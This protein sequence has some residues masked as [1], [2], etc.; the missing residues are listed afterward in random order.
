MDEATTSRVRARAF[1]LWTRAGRPVGRD[2]DIWLEAERHVLAGA[3][4][5]TTPAKD[6][7]ASDSIE[8][9]ETPRTSTPTDNPPGKPA[10]KA[11]A[12]PR[13]K[14]ARGKGAKKRSGPKAQPAAR[15]Q[16]RADK[17]KKRKPK[18]R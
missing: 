11:A 18:G 6:A 15:P 7:D 3:N 1:L 12:Q 4:E 16:A 17:P 14:G 5:R 2:L 13:A 9:Q 10:K 8:A